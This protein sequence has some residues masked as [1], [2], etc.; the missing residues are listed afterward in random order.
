MSMQ[1]QPVADSLWASHLFRGLR[2]GKLWQEGIST[3]ETSTNRSG[4]PKLV[5][6]VPKIKAVPFVEG[7][8]SD[9]KWYEITWLYVYAIAHSIHILINAF[10]SDARSCLYFYALSSK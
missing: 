6:Q 5:R 9:K 7:I 1:K 10:L 2:L 4:V 8:K 3:C